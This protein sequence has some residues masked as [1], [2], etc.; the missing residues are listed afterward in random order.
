MTAREIEETLDAFG[1]A[2]RRA[3]EAGFDGVQLHCAHG[4]PA[5]RIPLAAHQPPH[6]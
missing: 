6:R 4:Y 1:Q 2:A 5:Q 3:R